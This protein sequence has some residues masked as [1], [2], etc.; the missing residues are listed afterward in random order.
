MSIRKHLS[1]IPGWRTSR[2]LIVLESDD[3][4]SI[5]TRSNWDY[6]QMLSK[7]LNVDKS[8]FTKYDCLES[9]DDLDRLF[10]LLKSYKDV[11]GNNP[12]FTPM[13]VVAN[14]DFDKISSSNF[15]NYFFEP[16]TET[17]K[18]YQN[19]D[20]VINLWR[21]GI[22]EKIFIPQ[23]HGREHLNS[24][25]WL[26]ALKKSDKGVQ[27]S[28]EHGSIGSSQ[29]SGE[30]I[31]EYL[32][33][34]DPEYIEDVETYKEILISGADLF[35]K[36][37]RYYPSHFVASNK[38]EPKVLEETL[39]LIGIKS[40]IRYKFHNYPNGNGTTT[41]EINWLGKKNKFGQLALTRNCG[42]EPSDPSISDWY[43]SCMKDIE[44]AFF[45][46][47]PAV[48][49]THRVNYVGGLDQSNADLGLNALDNLLKGILKR[50][51]DAE[52]ITSVEL[53]NLIVKD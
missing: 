44:I 47:K 40:L 45:W 52:F 10:N 23:Y 43:S 3:W 25:R 6:D 4:G 42:F 49:S 27:I 5:R 20:N 12:V 17:C 36:L 32:A 16:F 11:N 18:K 30:N 51:P 26:R 8:N 48:V 38:P 34:F 21:I 14:P 39:N 24:Q 1:N 15:E 7:G 53:G 29:I 2:K 50:W 33:A 19:Q 41:K 9:N 22:K 46:S 31:P 28:F 37:L 13:C 35:N